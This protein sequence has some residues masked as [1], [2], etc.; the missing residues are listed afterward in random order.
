MK[1]IAYLVTALALPLLGVVIA[2][3]P[4]A[5]QEEN[6]GSIKNDSSSFSPFVDDKGQ[7]KFLKR[8]SVD[9]LRIE[10]RGYSSFWDGKK[11]IQKQGLWEGTVRLDLP[12]PAKRDQANPK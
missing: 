8:E 1:T 3:A 9:G 10:L 4:A 6:R 12:F 11:V 5:T 7:I 2:S